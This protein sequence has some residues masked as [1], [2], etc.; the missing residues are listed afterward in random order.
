M[1]AEGTGIAGKVIYIDDF[2]TG[3]PVFDVVPPAPVTG[4]AVA[5]PENYKTLLPGLMYRA[6]HRKLILYTTAGLQL[7]TSMQLRLRY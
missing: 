4:L 5:A 7:Q 6:K 2:W 1:M 3:N